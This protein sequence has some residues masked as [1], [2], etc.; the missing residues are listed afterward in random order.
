MRYSSDLRKRVIDFVENGGSKTEAAS[1]FNVSRGSVH[2]WTSAE[3]GLSYK[4]PGPK[5]PRSLDLKAL[6]LH[7]ETNDDMTQ[8]ERAQHFGVSRA[9]IWYNMKQLGITRKKR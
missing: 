6:R 2:N 5:G 7:V 1:Q 9:C 4:K 8:S 3:D